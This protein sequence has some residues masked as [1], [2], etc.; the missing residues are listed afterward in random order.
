MMDMLL[1]WVVLVMSSGTGS[2]SCVPSSCVVP[3][4]PSLVLC[5]VVVVSDGGSLVMAVTFREESSVEDSTAVVFSLVTVVLAIS[6]LP[7]CSGS[8]GLTVTSSDA[9][10]LVVVAGCSSWPGTASVVVVLPVVLVCISEAA[11]V[12]VVM[13]VA[14]VTLTELTS[15]TVSLEAG[16]A[17]VVVVVV[18]VVTSVAL[19]GGGSPSEVAFWVTLAAVPS[20]VPS[21]GFTS[22]SPSVSSSTS[23]AVGGASPVPIFSCLMLSRVA[24]PVCWKIWLKSDLMETSVVVVVVVRSV[25]K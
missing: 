7:G 20:T 6:T 21:T 18:L 2:L 13:F 25:E 14:S 15:G 8:S 5:S 9:A 24:P 3:V 16:D 1:W 19:V 17:G 4:S 22:V 11:G 23:F 12:V 10:F